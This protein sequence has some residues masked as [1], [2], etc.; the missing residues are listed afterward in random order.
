MKEKFERES[1]RRQ[2]ALKDY[3]E[4]ELQMTETKTQLKVRDSQLKQTDEE[5]RTLNQVRIITL[6]L[7]S[8]LHTPW[9]INNVI[10]GGFNIT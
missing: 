10:K 6:F 4:L 5:N 2:A 3:K 1:E 7:G 9:T 8:T